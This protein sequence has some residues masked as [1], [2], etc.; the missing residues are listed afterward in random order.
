MNDVSFL[1]ALRNTNTCED[2]A[3]CGFNVY[4]IT[5]CDHQPPNKVQYF[6]KKVDFIDHVSC[7]LPLKSTFTRMLLHQRTVKL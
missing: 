3:T 7:K 1:P 2:S 4:S 6:V 5:S